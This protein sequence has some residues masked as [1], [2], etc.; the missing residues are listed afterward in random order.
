MDVS[1]IERLARICG[2]GDAY[3]DYRGELR[4]F[5]LETKIAILRAMGAPL[6]DA[7]ALAQELARRENARWRALLP[8]VAA[9]NGGSVG[10]DLNIAA[11]DFGATFSWSVDVEQ[12]GRHTGSRSTADCPESWR[13]EV[14]GSWITRRR[15]ELPIELPPG[16]HILEVSLGT[17]AASRCTLLISPQRCYE[18][19][20]SAT[21]AVSGASRSSSIRC[22]RARIGA[23]A[24]SAIL[25]R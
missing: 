15:F 9:F 14:A 6:D 24:I 13:G 7:A 18:P 5:T 10:I 20:P 2:V 16:R 23:S 21:G 1:L 12:G 11:V 4:H 8:P 19:Q 25:R 22:A 17:A 3:H